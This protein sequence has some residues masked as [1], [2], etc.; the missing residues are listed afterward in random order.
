M[1]LGLE[2][3]PD[4]RADF[5]RIKNFLTFEFEA[6]MYANKMCSKINKSFDNFLDFPKIGSKIKQGDE[7]RKYVVERY[8]LIYQLKKELI[9]IVRIF[10]S[11][12]NELMQYL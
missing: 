6:P 9:E 3:S 11:K 2:I 4:A 8:V 12:E 7:Q 5:K 10:D 1:N